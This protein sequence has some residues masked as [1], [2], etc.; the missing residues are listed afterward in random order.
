MSVCLSEMGVVCSLILSKYLFKLLITQ[1]FP[2]ANAKCHELNE[3]LWDFDPFGQSVH[4]ANSSY[5]FGSL[6]LKYIEITIS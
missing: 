1:G 3:F 6:Q 2:I 4:Q 5:V